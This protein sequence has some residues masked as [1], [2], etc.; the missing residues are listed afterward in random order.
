MP[1]T[2]FSRFPDLP[3]EL[4]ILVWNLTPFPDRVIGL[5][6]YSRYAQGQPKE[7]E[8]APRGQ[9]ST[10]PHFVHTVQPSHLGIFPPLHVNQE[11]RSVW[12]RRLVQTRRNHELILSSGQHD[13]NNDTVGSVTIQSKVPFISYEYDIFAVYGA[14][15]PPARSLVS[16]DNRAEDI[17]PID[18]F[19]GFERSKIRR[20]G[21]VELPYGLE[22][23]IQALDIRQLAAL[24]AF[25][26]LTLGP[27]PRGEVQTRQTSIV[28]ASLDLEMAVEDVQ[29]VQCDIKNIDTRIIESHPF[30]NMGRLRH[31]AALSP[32]IRPL[33]KYKAY[34]KALLWHAL[35]RNLTPDLDSPELTETRF[36]FM[37]YVF[38]GSRHDM[39]PMLA[40]SCGTGGHGRNEMI[41]WQGDFLM[42]FRIICEKHWSSTAESIGIVLHD[43]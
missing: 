13:G 14:W 22:S 4:R 38:N 3:A 28:P 31:R 43:E 9:S 16:T 19:S 35:S 7:N 30:F 1:S 10:E 39:C 41:K 5:V 34:V 33:Q 21:L 11:A 6:P 32:A 15:R 2:V 25:S 17:A 20:I 8:K 29:T 18:P 24:D 23:A 36:E 37:Q 12:L 40:G 42:L 26:F 27:D